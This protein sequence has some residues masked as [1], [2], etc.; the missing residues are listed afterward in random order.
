[1]KEKTLTLLLGIIIGV[2]VAMFVFLI[3]NL[4]P[5]NNQHQEE[6]ESIAKTIGLH[7]DT[8]AILIKN[9]DKVSNNNK[10]LT[11]LMNEITKIKTQIDAITKTDT[12]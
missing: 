11:H 7:N 2:N 3:H 9:N 5:E 6:I 10:I 8:L 4:I 1:M 12:N